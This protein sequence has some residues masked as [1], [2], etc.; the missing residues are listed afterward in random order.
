MVQFHS[1]PLMKMLGKLSHKQRTEH[2][3]QYWEGREESLAKEDKI[4]EG[5]NQEES[6]GTAG[7]FGAE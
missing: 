5:R 6:Y 4:S 1:F 2:G 7:Q 3:D